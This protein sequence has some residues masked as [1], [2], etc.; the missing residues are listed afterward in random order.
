MTGHLTTQQIEE[1]LIDGADVQTR[2][3]LISCESCRSEW[4]HLDEMLQLY[5]SSATL[6]A[7]SVISPQPIFIARQSTS[8]GN[9]PRLKLIFAGA[10]LVGLFLPFFEQHREHER[11]A[12]QIARDNLLL[13]QVDQA[14][15]EPVPLPLESLRHLVVSEKPTTPTSGNSKKVF[16]ENK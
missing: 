14:V 10:I 4:G 6:T 13:E 9:L 5:K 15:S 11:H 1:L 7:D 16:N 12:A 8:R 2:D 3:H